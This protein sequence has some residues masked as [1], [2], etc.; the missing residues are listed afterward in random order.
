MAQRYI[1]TNTFFEGNNG[2]HLSRAP[3]GKSDIKLIPYTDIFPFVLSTDLLMYTLR[4]IVRQYHTGVFPF[5]LCQ[6]GKKKERKKD[7]GNTHP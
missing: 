1:D 6:G 5:C 4:V 7:P 2:G 3:T